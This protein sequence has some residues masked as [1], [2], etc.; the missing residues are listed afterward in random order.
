MA[1]QCR[2]RGARAERFIETGNATPTGHAT[3]SHTEI[4]GNTVK[5]TNSVG[6]A[7]AD[8]GGL[9]ADLAMTV[10]DDV[11]ADNRVVVA[12][13]GSGSADGDSG[14]GELW[15]TVTGT[16]LTGNTVTISAGKGGASASSGASLIQANLTDSLVSRNHVRAISTG[17]SAT[18]VAGGIQVSGG[19]SG[20]RGRNA[21]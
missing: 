1:V 7:Y 5:M 3:I 17:G 9:K 13:L 18:A 12:A 10:T 21:S 6:A 8:S 15:G 2:S 4:T 20:P 16:R 11:I 14:A 19:V